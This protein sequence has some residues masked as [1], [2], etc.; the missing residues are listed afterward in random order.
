MRGRAPFSFS[1]S[2]PGAPFS[3][4]YNSLQNG[5]QG[6]V[7]EDVLSLLRTF[8]LPVIKATPGEGKGVAPP[9]DILRHSGN[10]SSSCLRCSPNPRLSLQTF[11]GQVNGRRRDTAETALRHAQG[12]RA[13]L[14]KT[15]SRPAREFRWRALRRQRRVGV[16]FKDRQ[17]NNG[18]ALDEDQKA[19]LPVIFWFV[20]DSAIQIH[21]AQPIGGANGQTGAIRRQGDCVQ[22]ATARQTARQG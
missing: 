20:P 2:G 3:L 4:F 6:L 1:Q 16:E 19:V 11:R 7:F 9:A 18:T 21:G 12:R 15:T 5:A 13:A 14:Q 8:L 22:D 10:L 17:R